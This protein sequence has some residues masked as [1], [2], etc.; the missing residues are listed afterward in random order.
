MKTNQILSI[1]TGAFESHGILLFAHILIDTDRDPFAI[2]FARRQN[3]CNAEMH[4]VIVLSLII[5]PTSF[6]PNVVSFQGHGT[7]E[8]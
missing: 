6:Y 7:I 2:S 8:N 1:K 4:S 3:R 5:D